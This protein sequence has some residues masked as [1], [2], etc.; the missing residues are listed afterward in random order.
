[1]Y[2]FRTESQ[3]LV[4]IKSI[5]DTLELNERISRNF[6]RDHYFSIR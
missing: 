3:I 6:F 5:S 2:V 1:M 4:Y